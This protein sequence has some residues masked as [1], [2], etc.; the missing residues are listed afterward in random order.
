MSRHSQ[1]NRLDRFVGAGCEGCSA[2]FTNNQ[3]ACLP[4]CQSAGRPDACRIE[5]AD[6]EGCSGPALSISHPPM[7]S[8]QAAVAVTSRLPATTTTTTEQQQQQQHQQ[9]SSAA[10]HSAAT[11]PLSS[12]HPEE[13][14]LRCMRLLTFSRRPRRSGLVVA[15]CRSDVT[16]PTGCDLVNVMSLP[17][18]RLRRA[19]SEPEKDPAAGLGVADAASP[20]RASVLRSFN[21]ARGLDIHAVCG[22]RCWRGRGQSKVR[23][24]LSRRLGR[25]NGGQHDPFAMRMAIESSQ[26]YRAEKRAIRWSEPV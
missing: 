6:S 11:Q 16:A 17:A 15:G 23:Q 8:M 9:S 24:G 20:S 26:R 10:C 1:Q 4:A 7:V 19:A 21:G 3:G 13:L 18:S 14:P 2:G 22:W 12:H 25:Y 5:C